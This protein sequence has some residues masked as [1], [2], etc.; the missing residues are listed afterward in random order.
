M[1]RSIFLAAVCMY[2]SVSA[3]T[4]DRSLEE[5]APYIP[6]EKVVLP[7]TVVTASNGR[8]WIEQCDMP[9]LKSEPAVRVGSCLSFFVGVRRLA[10]GM[11]EHFCNQQLEGG[12]FTGAWDVTMHIARENPEMPIEDVISQ[13]MRFVAPLPCRKKK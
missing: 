13:T 11:P 3:Q 12:Q 1:K 8:E 2:G 10:M 9:V 5:P 7:F 6:T 4:P